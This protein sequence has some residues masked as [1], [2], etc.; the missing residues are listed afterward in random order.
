M[1]PACLESALVLRAL[2]QSV[3]LLH[4][5]PVVCLSEGEGQRKPPIIVWKEMIIYHP[6][7]RG[8]WITGPKAGGLKGAV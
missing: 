7:I 3:D 2:E 5:C 6:V 1:Q 4:P 8:D